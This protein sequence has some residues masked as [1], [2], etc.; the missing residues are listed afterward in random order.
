MS[1]DNLLKIPETAERLRCQAE[2]V[3][4]LLRR[5]DLVGVKM[6]SPNR[7]GTWKVRE[8]SIE[9]FLNGNQYRV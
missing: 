4:R 2:T 1:K 8:S 9:R 7:G 5:G 3:R 6:P